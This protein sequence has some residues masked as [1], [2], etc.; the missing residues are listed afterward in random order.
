VL[1][2]TL[3]VISA[4][5]LLMWR[6]CPGS[7]RGDR[8][9]GT[10]TV[11]NTSGTDNVSGNLILGNQSTGNGTYNLTYGGTLTVSGNATIESW[12]RYLQPGH[13]GSIGCELRQQRHHYR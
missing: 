11:N 13:S 2:N 10:D 6:N 9:T 1:K 4:A 5:A 12:H 3:R 7:E 8:D